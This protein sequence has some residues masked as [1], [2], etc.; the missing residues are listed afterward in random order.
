MESESLG[1]VILGKKRS[2]LTP[3]V[4]CL[5][6]PSGSLLDELCVWLDRHTVTPICR[7]ELCRPPWN[8]PRPIFRASMLWDH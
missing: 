6:F 8:S 4:L 2:S 7:E 3:G 5:S 1:G